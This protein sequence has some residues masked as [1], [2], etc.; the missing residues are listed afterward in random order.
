[1]RKLV[2]IASVCMVLFSLTGCGTEYIESEK[3]YHYEIDGVEYSS[4]FYDHYMFVDSFTKLSDEP[5]RPKKHRELYKIDNRFDMYEGDFGFNGNK[6]LL[7][8]SKDIEE[9]RDY[10]SDSNNYDWY[11]IRDYNKRYDTDDYIKYDGKV[12]YAMFHKLASTFDSYDPVYV[13]RHLDLCDL[14]LDMWD[15]NECYTVREC[16]KDGLFKSLMIELYDYEGELYYFI[17]SIGD[18]KPEDK[19]YYFIKIEEDL[20]GGFRDVIN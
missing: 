12:D 3:G 2:C 10:Y 1:M 17:V 14:R 11:F 18:G 7:V 20:Q 6:T 19:G 8:S 9:A 13:S 4:R 15:R 16:S 5:V